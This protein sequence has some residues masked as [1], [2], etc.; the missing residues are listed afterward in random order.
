MSAQG[1][2]KNTAV[3]D[4]LT[5]SARAFSF[6]QTVRLL[7]CVAAAAADDRDR[8][9]VGWIGGFKP[10]DGEA[11]RFGARQT[12]SFPAAEVAS[13]ELQD[14]ERGQRW[15]VMLNLIGLTGAMGV[16]PQHYSELVLRRRRQKDRSLEHF[17]NLFN[18]RTASLFYRACIKYRL[19]LQIERHRLLR[20]PGPAP[21]TLALMSLLGLATEGLF[22][23]LHVGDQALVRYAGL[24]NQQVRTP[25]NLVQILRS[26]FGIPV[27]VRQFIGQW[28]EL[29]DDVRSRLPDIDN[30]N[31][32][33]AVLGRSAM[34]GRRGWFAQGKIQIIL[35]PLCKRQLKRFAPGTDTLKA[36]N[37]LVRL[38]VGMEIDYELVI[39]LYHRD[40]PEKTRLQRDEPPI[41][42]WNTWLRS[43]PRARPAADATLDIS[44]SA[45]RMA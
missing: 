14:P 10:P 32:R 29:I 27:A 1:R 15:R 40:I 4:E 3:I 2:R 18:H 7:E 38:Y 41:M 8:G 25:G 45:N 11:I 44:V 31:G 6:V 35:G 21:P 9:A 28:Q 23:R 17:L 43:K 33:N 37:E 42:G 22:D 26:H 16:L 36:L 30:P 19:P 39:R 24:F 5:Q 12:L 34:L 20:A 13:V